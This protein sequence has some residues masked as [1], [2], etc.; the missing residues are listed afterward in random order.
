MSMKSVGVSLL[1]WVLCLGHPYIRKLDECM[2]WSAEYVGLN[3]WTDWAPNGAIDY[4]PNSSGGQDRLLYLFW[5]LKDH[6]SPYPVMSQIENL[7][8]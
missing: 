1:T 5:G 8:P 7:G 2:E 4:E 6:L 3:W